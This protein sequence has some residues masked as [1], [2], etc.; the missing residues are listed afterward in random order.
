MKVL[1]FGGTSVGSIENIERVKELITD[2]DKKIV[3]LSAMSG[4]TNIL[5]EISELI[6]AEEPN[7]ALEIIETLCKKYNGVIDDLFETSELK[8]TVGNYIDGIF[9]YLKSL[10]SEKHSELLY[11]KIVSQGELMSTYMFTQFLIQDGVNARLLPALDFMRIDK[12]FEPD[13]FYIKQNL[14]RIIDEALPADI[15]IT[16]GFICLDAYGNVANLQRGGSD[17]TATIIGAV[18]EADEVQ[19]WT[20]ID[21]MHNND[22][23][24]VENTHAISNLSFDEAAELAYFGAKILHPQTVMPAM[25]ANIPVRLKNT[26][27]PESYG[28]L[29]SQQTDGDGIKAIAAKDNITAIKI[30]SARML[31][32]HGFLKKVFEIFEKYETPIDMITT[33]EIAVSLTIDNDTHL[34]SIVEELDKFSNVEVDNQQSIICLVGHSIVSHS[35]THRLF[36]VLQDIPVR[37]ISY[38]GSKNN[39]SLLVSTEDK[40]NALQHLNKY[41][42]EDVVS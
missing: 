38:G 16:Q 35:E 30:K 25:E 33:S 41:V 7:K 40:I 39:I 20:D 36:R 6:K 23:R 21:G 12:S 14:Q 28:T 37:M 32:A 13:E 19:I 5:V 42:F 15:Y 3:V 4:T 34:T 18:V 24:F 27:D 26:M 29:I 11:N 9:E 8:Q 2:G 17:Y 10:T 31:L 22:P 1:K